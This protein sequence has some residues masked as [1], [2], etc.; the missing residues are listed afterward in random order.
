M[1]SSIDPV[2]V[3]QFK[4]INSLFFPCAFQK[5]I[6]QIFH[7]HLNFSQGIYPFSLRHVKDDYYYIFSQQSNQYLIRFDITKC[8]T[9][10]K[11]KNLS[12]EV[13]QVHDGFGPIFSVNVS[14]Y[15]TSPMKRMFLA[16]GVSDSGAFHQI[17]LDI[18]T[19]TVRE[20]SIADLT[21]IYLLKFMKDE[22]YV[23]GMPD[24]TL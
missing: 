8:F 16:S 18:E 20:L 22:I 19:E 14:N 11:D 24:S 9:G 2:P 17:T 15:F 4:F 6:F 12:I 23:I 5:A 3:L 10:V 21:N 1:L 7:S 13:I